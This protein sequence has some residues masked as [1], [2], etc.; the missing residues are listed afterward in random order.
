[1]PEVGAVAGLGVSLAPPEDGVAVKVTVRPLIPAL[2]A[3]KTCATSGLANGVFTTADWPEPD[4]TFMVFGTWP[5]GTV[6]VLGFAGFKAPPPEAF[7]VLLTLVGELFG[8][9][10]INV[11]TG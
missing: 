6:S 11:R 3:S 2:P 5:T 8:I 4:M 1:V 10:T 9:F 7:A